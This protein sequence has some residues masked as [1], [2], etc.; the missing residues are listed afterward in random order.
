MQLGFVSAILG[1]L[2]LEQVLAFAAA[3]GFGCVE[4]MCW[5]PGGADRRYAGVTHL[6]VTELS[7]SRL[8]WLRELLTRSG[9]AISGLG[10][11]P[12]PLHP[13]PE[14]RQ[15]VIGHL[16]KVISAAPF[17]NVN[18][19]NTFIGRDSKKSIAENWPLVREVWPGIV[20][21][22]AREGVTLGIEN[23]PMLF[24]QDEWPGGAN[25][26]TTPAVWRKMFE[27]IP[28]P[29]LGL[30]FDP[31]HLIWQHIDPVRAI[32]EFGKRIVHFHAKD[33]RIDRDQLYETGAMGLGWHT[34]KI[35]GLGDVPWGP[36]FSALSDAGYRGPVCIEVEDRAFEGSLE[37][38]KQSLRQSKRF[39]EQYL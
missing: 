21:H 27:D 34:P 1:D 8:A 25:L 38:R 33:T 19:V 5:P 10:Y 2:T 12:N 6:D 31:S 11:Y 20:E 26:A 39:L 28:H 7:T 36:V 15:R 16:K 32:R 4:L 35:P 13:D 23:C 14:H 29:R 24:T 17:L 3:E 9:V 37:H 18:V 22:A 30:N